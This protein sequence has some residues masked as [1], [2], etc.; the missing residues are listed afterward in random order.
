MPRKKRE[1]QADGF[2]HC[3]LRGNNRSNV[4]PTTEDMAEL[5]RA[6]KHVHA[7][8]PFTVYAFCFMTNHYHVLLR[9]PDGNL[10]KIMS[11]INKRYSDSYRSRHN[12]TGR[13]YQ[14]RFFAKHVD[15]YR[16]LL[17][18]S[19]YIHR[20]PI[21]T[22]TPMVRDLVDYPYSSFPCYART[23]AAPPF[24]DLDFLP[25]LLRAPFPPTPEGYLR[26]VL[27]RKFFAEE[28]GC[29]LDEDVLP[30]G[31][32]GWRNDSSGNEY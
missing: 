13:I 2:Y 19:A 32:P 30:Y 15:T 3:I 29:V 9:A 7:L 5:Y 6:F 23:K 14:R 10:S 11:L 31:M 25:N 16:G 17:E 24:L 21:E 28:D 12:F 18:V 26:Y 20:N 4:F 1:F 8:Y 22:Q 27:H